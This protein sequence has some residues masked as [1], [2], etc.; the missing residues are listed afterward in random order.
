MSQ[1]AKISVT[2]HLSY[3]DSAGIRLSKAEV[4]YEVIQA[5]NILSPR[6][7]ESLTEQR[8]QEMIDLNIAAVTVKGPA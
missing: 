5:V 3:Y 7:G 8:L 2:Q 6:I 4:S 1:A